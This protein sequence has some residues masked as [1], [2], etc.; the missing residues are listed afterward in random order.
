M[1]SDAEKIEI[2][3][4]DGRFS[5]ETDLRCG[6]NCWS[7]AGNRLYVF[8]RTDDRNNQVAVD[9]RT[10]GISGKLPAMHKT[11]IV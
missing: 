6:Y 10:Q 7:F 1:N 2:V 4:V 9:V 11:T 3:G 8:R 5:I